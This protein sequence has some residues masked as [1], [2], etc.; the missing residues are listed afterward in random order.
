MYKRG[1]CCRLG[2][3][4]FF[5]IISM[6][7]VTGCSKE[8]VLD[9]YHHTVEKMGE[10]GLTSAS[11]LKGEKKEG[12]DGYVGT[13]H[14]SYKEFSGT[15]SVFGGTSARERESGNELMVTCE[16]TI[17]KGSAEVFFI[18]G[19]EEKKVL[20][21]TDGKTKVSVTLPAASNYICIS[22]DDFTGELKIKVE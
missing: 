10:Q 16:I 4:A 18:S 5:F 14:A 9:K 22:G 20:T 13:Y 17:E 6:L 3:M 21:D 8:E 11:L 7:T 12:E 19:D 2:L 15:E 1:N